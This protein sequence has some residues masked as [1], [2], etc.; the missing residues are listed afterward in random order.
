MST[1]STVMVSKT[2]HYNDVDGKPNPNNGKRW[3]QFYHHYDGYEMGV[4][5][6]LVRKVLNLMDRNDLSELN[7]I[8]DI[9]NALLEVVDG[10]YQQE[11]D[12]LLHG[13]IEYLY[14]VDFDDGIK[15]WCY[16]RGDWE[17]ES[18]ENWQDWKKKN[19]IF[20]YSLHQYK[21]GTSVMTIRS[22]DLKEER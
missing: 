3:L 8:W 12:K 10:F 21:N 9:E 17:N 7:S 14:H 11:S 5:L 15:I 18:H 4:G 13:D 22:I 1:R 20:D 2:Q 19:L 16:E 6:D